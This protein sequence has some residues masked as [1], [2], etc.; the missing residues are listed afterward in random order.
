MKK[1]KMENSESSNKLKL[2]F[3]SANLS[4]KSCVTIPAP[5]KLLIGGDASELVDTDFSD[6]VLFQKFKTENQKKEKTKNSENTG[7]FISIENI[8]ICE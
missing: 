1:I 7:K 5:L 6:F 8:Y 2:T 3:L 4:G